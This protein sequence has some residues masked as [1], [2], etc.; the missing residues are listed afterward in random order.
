[1]LSKENLLNLL[2]KYSE[3]EKYFDKYGIPDYERIKEL[4][5]SEI[6]SN[7]L[8]NK[9][10]LNVY[11]ILKHLKIDR[12]PV[13]ENLIKKL[14]GFLLSY[15]DGIEYLWINDSI[16]LLEILNGNFYEGLKNYCKRLFVFTDNSMII[17]NDY[18][19]FLSEFFKKLDNGEIIFELIS[20]VSQK[21]FFINL[22]YK[23]R[24]MVFTWM[25]FLYQ[26][27]KGSEQEKV[28]K[29]WKIYKETLNVLIEAG[30]IRDVMYLE[31]LIYTRSIHAVENLTDDFVKIENDICQPCR[32]LYKSWISEH[33]L[34]P[35]KSEINKEGKIKI[36]IVR[37][38][39]TFWSPFKLEFSLVKNLLQEKDFK[40]KYE[41]YF[42]SMTLPDFGTLQSEEKCVELL[43]TID[44]EVKKPVEKYLEQ[45]LYANRHRLILEF[46]E[47][48]IK[49]DIDIII[50]SDHFYSVGEFLF[51]SRAAP[52]QIYWCHLNHE[53][54]M[55]G[56]DKRIIHY[57]PPKD[58]RFKDAFEMFEL[59]LDEM[60][61]K[62]DEE[63]NKEEAKKIR[64]RF[65]ENTVILG[66]IGRLLKV[67]N[68]DYLSAVAEILKS[69]PD[70][71]YLACG[72]GNENSVREK[73]RKLG[74]EKRFFF[75]GF[76]NPKIYRYVIDIYLNTFPFHSGEAIKEFM[77]KDEESFVV[78]CEME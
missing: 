54:D 43:R 19:I 15:R 63:K 36:A 48:L 73:V 57:P 65:P 55:E 49:D 53:V 40:E 38:T 26:Y 37:P 35:C 71:V 58:S 42:Y 27:L 76:V 64:S 29:L 75:E 59:E 25:D 50:Y 69:N 68:Y 1:M 17:G 61:L 21:D 4:I 23:E 6:S 24:I 32:G 14:N 2:Q 60:F 67:D 62:A 34:T 72:T 74:I 47:S 10:F 70:T 5:V 51:L 11:F 66:S 9:D 52:K 7:N 33:N 78:S 39:I 22:K 18:D 45:G 41:L 28:K 56:I 30:H 13:I 31:N 8:F 16:F 20:S 46:R 44:V 77:A 12:E 3:D